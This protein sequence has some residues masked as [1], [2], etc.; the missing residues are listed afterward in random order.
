VFKQQG[1]FVEAE[2]NYT[3]AL[4]MEKKWLGADHPEVAGTLNNLAILYDA[5]GKWADAAE[6]Y[7][8]ALVI[9]ENTQG[10]EHP[11]V[12]TTLNNLGVAYRQQGNITGAEAA[13]K[14]ALAI[15]EKIL[16]ANHPNVAQTLN[17][18]AI[19]AALRDDGATAALAYSRKATSVLIA[20]AA[21]DAAAT[22]PR[23]DPGGVI[24]HRADIF[25]RHVASL[26]SASRAGL[27][28]QSSL[29]GE[30]FEIAQWQSLIGRT[31]PAAARRPHCR[32]Q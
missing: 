6:L 25:Q 31:R 14:R 2:R 24:E 17:N 30:A 4:A 22:S 27:E 10:A 16:G 18:L 20:H 26:W 23:E 11:T 12:A 7:K 29:A 21:I 9:L 15:R 13:F 1:K 3:R 19:S 5:Q 28:P 32:G 8:R